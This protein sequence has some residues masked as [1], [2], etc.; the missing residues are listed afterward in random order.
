MENPLSW[1]KLEHIID[2]AIEEHRAAVERGVIGGSRV[3]AIASAIRR[4]GLL[5][6]DPEYDARPCEG[7]NSN[8]CVAEGCYGEACITPVINPEPVFEVEEPMVKAAVEISVCPDCG[9]P[10]GS[11]ACK[12]RHL[13]INTGAAKSSRDLNSAN[14]I[15]FKRS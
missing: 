5:A 7:Q 10:E 12:V 11:F 14:D 15:K 13:Q 6:D 2:D 3:Y 1:R 9:K 8:V 4:S